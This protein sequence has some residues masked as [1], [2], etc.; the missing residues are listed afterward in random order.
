M[1]TCRY[2][3]LHNGARPFR[4]PRR[5]WHLASADDHIE[6][7]HGHDLDRVGPPRHCPLRH[8]ASGETFDRSQRVCQIGG[9]EKMVVARHLDQLDVDIE[10]W[11]D[12]TADAAIVAGYHGDFLPDDRYDDWST[13]LRDEIRA[14]YAAAIRRLADCSADKDAIELWR[15]A[16]GQDPYDERSHRALVVTLRAEG[17]LGEARSAYQS[18]VAAMDDLEVPPTAWDQLNP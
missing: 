15:K 3:S 16:L 14:R 4:A 10:R 8:A 2:E 17:R 13:P 18:Y 6:A 12:L 11:F 7:S 1:T 9:V 5:R